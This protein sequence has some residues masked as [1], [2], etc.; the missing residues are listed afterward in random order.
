MYTLLKKLFILLFLVAYMLLLSC[1]SNE[2]IPADFF[3]SPDGND[4]WSG[5]L[6]EPAPGGSDGPFATLA[7]ARDAVR[8][9][10]PG[11]ER[12][13]TVMLRGGRYYHAE[14]VH[15]GPED[16]G[17]DNARVIYAA[18]PGEMPVLVG[19]VRIDG[20][21]D[22]GGGMFRA[23]NP[24]DH[25]F[26][27]LFADS[28]RVK[29]ARQPNSGYLLSADSEV[30]DP[31]VQFPFRDGD[32]PRDAAAD[33]LRVHVW[34]GADWFTA[35]VPV[36]AIDHGRNIITLENPTHVANINWRNNRRYYLEGARA[37]L[38]SPNEFWRDP[39]TGDLLYIPGDGAISGSEIV[40]PTVTRI[41]E[42]C[43]E[44]PDEPVKNIEFHGIGFDISAFG[45]V[46]TETKLGTHGDTPWN[47]P[48]NKDAA[49]YLEHAKNCAV[50]DC[51]IT[52]AG[53]SG[54]GIVW[55]G[56]GNVISGCEITGCGFHAVLLSGYRAEFGREM[57]VNRGNT[58]TNNWLHHCGTLAGHG[59]GVFVW[60]SGHNDITHNRIHNM[61][62]YGV[63][64][65]G[66]RYGG[67]FPGTLETLGVYDGGERYDYVHS[68]HNTIAFNHIFRVSRD[69]E[70]NGFISF[71][72]PG[73][74]NVVDANLL[75]DI[76]HRDLGGLSMPI[77]LDDAADYITVSRN[78]MYNID[79]GTHRI[80]V[81]AKGMHNV[82][83]N[84]IMIGGPETRTAIR[85]FE[86]AGERVSHHIYRRN[87]MVLEGDTRV[88]TFRRWDGEKVDYADS[89]L[90]YTQ[91]GT[92]P[93]DVAG[94]V[95]SWDEWQQYGAGYDTHTIHADPGFVD[96]ANHDY[97]LRDGSPAFDIGFERIPVEE[98]G[99]RDGHRWYGGE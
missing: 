6:A 11:T 70:D 80:L 22:A 21:E 44:S 34:A 83:E 87:I 82:I 97:R 96:P 33:G 30:D 53:Y 3:V 94:E 10:L 64:V 27:Q 14:T 46:F 36:T 65:K 8:E 50:T 13:I 93:V 42:L 5:T 68:G 4:S 32:I 71:W 89:N 72:G 78:I 18:Y 54:V 91:S 77:Y 17:T 45:R 29:Y 56:T 60:A 62:R 61:P 73:K 1:G 75:H 74:G 52:N 28:K 24:P 31:Q 51:R 86:M 85:T 98:I 39:E 7:G 20:W 90:V 38:D 76:G 2:T 35:T 48:A 57:D 67:K 26:Y 19:G 49:V 55:S 43:G 40:A 66:Q 84:N 92:Y 63:C 12:D 15:F 9:R 81:F 95:L 16:S 99:L 58:V 79:S 59:A 88:Y 41:V 47:E 69:S 25:E 37:F 23:V